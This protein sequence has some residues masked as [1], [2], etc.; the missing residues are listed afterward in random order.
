[1]KNKK[2][3]SILLSAFL[4][5]SMFPIFSFSSNAASSAISGGETYFIKNK[6]TGKYLTATSTSSGANIYQSNFTG[7]NLQKFKLQ[8]NRTSNGNTYYS[9]LSYSNSQCCLDVSGHSNIE[10]AN[11]RLY[12]YNSNYYASQCFKLILTN[13]GTI[14]SYRIMPYISSSRVLSV[15]AG[16][17]TSGA[18]VELASSYL[19]ESYQDWIFEK[20]AN[21]PF[22]ISPIDI[23]TQNESDTC[24][25]ACATMIL[26]KYGIYV[27]ENE[28]KEK[29]FS[30]NRSNPLGY[31]YVFALRK[32]INYFLSSNGKTIRYMEEYVATDTDDNM[33][34]ILILLLIGNNRPIQIPINNQTG[35]NSGLPY[36]TPGHYIVIEGVKTGDNGNLYAIVADPYATYSGNSRTSDYSGIWEIP[37]NELKTFSFNHSSYILCE[38]DQSG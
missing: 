15:F 8:Y 18:N 31:T 38:E 19:S 7:S 16:Y 12:T 23:Y 35:T 27:S 4:L 1:M 3:L 28:I 34:G 24:G 10:G 9:F 32:A 22:V 30:Y 17:I 2:F 29:A 13:S 37:I 5:L 6:R 14:N 33:Y 25:S 36:R 11:I 26:S 20:T 21:D